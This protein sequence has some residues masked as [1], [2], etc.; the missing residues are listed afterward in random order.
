LARDED[1]ALKRYAPLFRRHDSGGSIITTYLRGDMPSMN[2]RHTHE[3]LQAMGL[4]EI[5]SVDAMS[6]LIRSIAM[7]V[8]G[9]QAVTVVSWP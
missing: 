9:D 6:G 3:T 8:R 2:S 5:P 4:T 7:A 1:F